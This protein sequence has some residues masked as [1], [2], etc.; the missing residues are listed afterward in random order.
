MQHDAGFHVLGVKPWWADPGAGGTDKYGN[1]LSFSRQIKAG[2]NPDEVDGTYPFP[3]PPFQ[4]GGTTTRLGVDGGFKTPILRNVALTAPYFHWG[5]YPNLESVIKFYNRGGNRRDY[6]DGTT[7][8]DDR[9]TDG[10]GEMDLTCGKGDNSGSGP[11]GDT[12]YKDLDTLTDCGSNTTGI[13]QPLGLSDADIAGLIVFLKALTDERVQCSK[14]PFDHP[15]LHI[16]DGHKDQ[17]SNGDGKA[18][19]ILRVLPATGAAG[20]TCL[21]NT[22]D[23]FTMNDL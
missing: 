18:D 1:P 16:V 3:L 12:P 23:L 7:D 20:G 6:D 21:Q 9:D 2:N 10:D 5:G 15:Q 11:Q 13:M 17:D 22:G 19:E 8:A 4:G 14:S